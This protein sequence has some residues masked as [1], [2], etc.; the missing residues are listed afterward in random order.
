MPNF[1]SLVGLEVV[2]FGEGSYSYSCHR[3][4]TKST[5][6]SKAEAWTLDWS[7]TKVDAI[8]ILKGTLP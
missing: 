2:Y 7:L 4:K 5:P 6:S 3:G 1:S 8:T